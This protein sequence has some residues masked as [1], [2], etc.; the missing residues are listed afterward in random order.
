MRALSRSRAGV[1]GPSHVAGSRGGLVPRQSCDAERGLR[2]APDASRQL[3]ALVGLLWRGAAHEYALYAM[4]AVGSEAP[5]A[6]RAHVCAALVGRVRVCRPPQRGRR[7][8]TWR[9]L[10]RQDASFK[11]PLRRDQVTSTPANPWVSWVVE[12]YS[13]VETPPLA[14]FCCLGATCENIYATWN[15]PR[16]PLL[17]IPPPRCR[18]VTRTKD[19]ESH[20]LALNLRTASPGSRRLPSRALPCRTRTDICSSPASLAAQRHSVHSVYCTHS[21]PRLEECA[22]SSGARMRGAHGRPT[23]EHLH[24]LLRLLLF[25]LLGG[26]RQLGA[27]GP[28]DFGNDGVVRDGLPRFVLV[29]DLRLHVELLRTTRTWGG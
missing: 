2:N 10:A 26:A 7:K 6:T 12:G 21:R 24:A 20:L 25:S 3:V 14:S 22:P 17:K 16:C 11:V 18:Q 23:K 9:A 28:F 4:L 13:G 5:H 1:H 29:D 8:G 15:S 19:K 27:E